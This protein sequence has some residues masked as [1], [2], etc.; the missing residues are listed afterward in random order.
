VSAARKLELVTAAKSPLVL[1]HEA[2]RARMRATTQQ[3]ID[4]PHRTARD[5][6]P[7]GHFRHGIF[8]PG[9]DRASVDAA[10]AKGK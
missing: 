6:G 3:L 1:E 4:N 5:H 2:W 10:F 9:V 8:I 7:D